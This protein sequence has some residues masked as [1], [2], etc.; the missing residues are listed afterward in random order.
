M[1]MYNNYEQDTA[2]NEY[3]SPNERKE[4]DEF[5]DAVQSTPV[6]RWVSDL[7]P[8][9][10]VER[11]I[12]RSV[13]WLQARYEFSAAER[14]RDARSTNPSRIAADDLVQSVFARHGQNRQLRFR[15][16]FLV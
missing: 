8:R 1:A 3:V 16:C 10:K 5:L 14:L 9:V 11:T 2:I 12:E 7:W 6:M 4:E 15:A 13:N